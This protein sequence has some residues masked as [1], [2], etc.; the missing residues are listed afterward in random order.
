V[1]GAEVNAGVLLKKGIEVSLV[2]GAEV[3]IEQT[4]SRLGLGRS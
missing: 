3:R 1:A 4:L 2:A